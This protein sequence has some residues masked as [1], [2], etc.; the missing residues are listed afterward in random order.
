MKN[1]DI[2]LELVN[3]KI[4][5]NDL[6]Q[7]FDKI[8]IYEIYNNKMILSNLSNNSSMLMKLFNDCGELQK[9]TQLFKCD[10]SL[11]KLM[12]YKDGTFGGGIMGKKGIE[13]QAHFTPINNITNIVLPSML[14][15][16]SSMIVGEYFKFQIN[17]KLTNIEESLDKIHCEFKLN[18]ISDLK[19]VISELQYIKNN[20]TSYTEDHIHNVMKDIEQIYY[21][22]QTKIMN[23][24]EINII[25]K[26][27][28]NINMVNTL[29]KNILDF[30][31]YS[32][33]YKRSSSLL[34]DINILLYKFY[35]E[36][37]D[38]KKADNIINII[39]DNIISELKETNEKI[40]EISDLF[41]QQIDS[42]NS[43][44][45]SIFSKVPY[46][47]TITS[48]VF[49]SLIS[50]FTFNKNKTISSIS[51][52]ISAASIIAAGK[53]GYDDKQNQNL[54]KYLENLKN[55]SNDIK[56]DFMHNKNI[57]LLESFISEIN[58]EITIYYTNK[59]G[60]EYYI[61]KKYA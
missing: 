6:I 41:I 19:T 43:N 49:S 8:K 36:K 17:N 52:S 12:H 51:L 16:M 39:K 26:S 54:E 1:N 32:D 3:D 34:I 28:S 61:I 7:N 40:I 2:K 4:E 47:I 45:D 29:N 13:G 35:I 56:N 44:K 14:L 38:L 60:K 48:S 20:I 33:M 23:M 59:D 55:I 30:N 37:S 21:Y 18:K 22:F 11:D 27:D 57:E 5:L 50:L 25:P 24:N 46:W 53:K 15:K 58:N 10:V 9:R 42:I 31:F